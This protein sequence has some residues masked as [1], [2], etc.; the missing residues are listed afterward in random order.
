MVRNLNLYKEV[1][2]MA[3]NAQKIGNKM[4]QHHLINNLRRQISVYELTPKKSGSKK[5]QKKMLTE[6]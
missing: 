3:T 6:I 5:H 1:D 4:A 2:D